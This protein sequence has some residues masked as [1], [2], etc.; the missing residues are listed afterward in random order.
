MLTRCLIDTQAL[1]ANVRALRSTLS[2]GALLAPTVK[3]NAYGHGITL[4]AQ[5]FLDAGA[6]WLCVDALHEARALREVGI[7]AP[8]YVLGYVGLDAIEEA[9]A[10]DCR[11][12]L[13]NHETL[14]RAAQLVNTMGTTARFHLK[15]ETGNNRQGLAPEA[16]LALARQVAQTPG[17][18][19]E[20]VASH[21]ANIEDTTDHTYARYQFDLFVSFCR[22]LEAEGIRPRLRHIAN[23]A[24]TLLWPDTHMEMVRPG[25]ATFG[26]WPSR[27]TL[28]AALLADRPR[29]ELCPALTWSCRI[30]QIKEVPAGEYIG[31]GCTYRTTHPTRLAIVP[32]GY[33]DGYPRSLSNIGYVL[34]HGRRAQ[35]RGRVCMNIIMVDVTDIPEAGLECEAILLGA[36]RGERISAEL[37]ADWA[38]TINYEVTTRIHERI[39]RVAV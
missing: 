24:A 4:A 12:V 34:I 13:Y 33:Y 9:L 37:M 11:L 20:G 19:L 3:G 16:A 31:Y 22:A 8:V 30:A 18:M 14:V 21:F 25:I 7:T 1:A 17:A 5:A 23:S 2:P 35:V 38:G 29:F 27:E 26:M 39:P 36:D 10:L 6:D 28:V 15:V 32:V